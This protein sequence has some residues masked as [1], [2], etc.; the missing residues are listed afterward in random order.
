M[1]HLPAS[2]WQLKAVV[3]NMKKI[4]E[5]D[6]REIKFRIWSDISGRMLMP[7]E[8]ER[9]SVFALQ[10]GLEPEDFI[11]LPLSESYNLMQYTGLK[12]KNGKKIYEGDIVKVRELVDEGETLFGVNEVE[13]EGA[14]FYVNLNDQM[15]L[16]GAYGGSL[17]D[18]HPENIEIIGNIHENPE[19]LK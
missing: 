7:Q 18:W 12:D 5:R 19:L 13:Y 2:H 17:C 6:M 3:N 8:M 9:Q 16:R 1:K 11:V 14:C 15:G 10:E 4:L